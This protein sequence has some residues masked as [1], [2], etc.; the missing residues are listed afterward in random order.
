M[1]QFFFLTSWWV[2]FY[3]LIGAILSLPWGM[4]IVRRTGPRPAAYINLLMTVVAFFHSLIVLKDIWNQEPQSFL[5]TW[6]K[7]ADL[8]LSFALEVSPI[9]VGAAVLIT[10]LSLLAQVY[11]LG[12]MEKDWALARFFGL[13]GFFQAA[14]SGLALSDS[15]FLSYALL[16]LLT[17]S[18]YLLVGSTLR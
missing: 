7:A 17:L 5:I 9:S 14:L 16:E 13:M 12:Y 11:A 6:F 8:D 10:G 2:P 3:G 1:A 4:G 15:L 18:T